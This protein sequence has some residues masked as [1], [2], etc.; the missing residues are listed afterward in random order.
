MYPFHL[1]GLLA[2]TTDK[3]WETNPKPKQDCITGFGF[4]FF[5][6]S[7]AFVSGLKREKMMVEIQ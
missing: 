4:G 6:T 1:F 3:A 5:F 2:G 7:K